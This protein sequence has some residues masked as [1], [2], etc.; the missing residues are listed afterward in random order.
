[1]AGEEEGGL[2][3]AVG[4]V[5]VFEIWEGVSGRVES[6]VGL[7]GAYA[8]CKGSRRWLPGGTWPWSSRLDVHLC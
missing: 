2:A 7:R 8:R 6:V 5:V 3:F 4:Y 1:M